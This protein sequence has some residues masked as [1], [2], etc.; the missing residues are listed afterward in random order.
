MRA[1]VKYHCTAGNTRGIVTEVRRHTF[2]FTATA[3]AVEEETSGDQRTVT[4]RLAAETRT[5][6]W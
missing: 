2:K 3:A 4:R 5:L 6:T 1:R